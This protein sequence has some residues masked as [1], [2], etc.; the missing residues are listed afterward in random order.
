M[1]FTISFTSLRISS[2]CKNSMHVSL[3]FFI[4]TMDTN[5]NYIKRGNSWVVLQPQSYIGW[6]PK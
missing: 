1:G 4:N 2:F 5:C 3:M 6:K